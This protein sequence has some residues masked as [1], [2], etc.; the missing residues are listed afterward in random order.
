M[1]QRC[2][3]RLIAALGLMLV[4]Q[5]MAQTFTTLH[6]FTVS[7]G[8]NPVAALILSSNTL[9][10]TTSYGGDL[11]NGT[12]FTVNTDGSGFTNLYSFTGGSD[13]ANPTAGL[14]LLSNTLYGVA[15]SGGN[16]G[17]G[18]VFAI[19]TSGT[20]FTNLYSFTAT[21]FPS[22]TNGDGANP[23]GLILS[24]NTFYGTAN[25]GGSFGQGTIFKVNINGTGFT[26][27]HNFTRGSDGGSPNTGLILSSNILYGTTFSG[28][29]F[30]WGTVFAVGTDSTGFTNLHSFYGSSDGTD[31]AAGL[32]LSGN[33]LYGTAQTGGDSGNGTVFRI[34]TDGTGFTN[35]HVFIS[36]S[37]GANPQASFV[38][39]SNTLY[40]STGSGGNSGVGTLFSI[41]LNGT[42]FNN[43]YNFTATFPSYPY[44]NGDGAH[45]S[46][47]LILL[48]NILYGTAQYG[49][50]SGVGTVF[51]LDLR[52]RVFVAQIN[53][54]LILTWANT[55]FT[56]QSAPLVTG[57]YTNISGATSPYTNP[58][59]AS[60][61]F[62]RLIGN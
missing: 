8:A 26:N 43:L 30:G 28:G 48:D 39:S 54:Q 37:D 38:L 16:S 20:S 58:I 42:G 4:G 47:S 11:G 1:N 24:G 3:F 44:I 60:Q 15:S 61:Q 13:G 51:K 27:L 9:Y 62:F 7:D 34:Y 36:T 5:A 41:K 18:T 21:P 10:G 46:A 32:V 53:N 23:N 56:L 52:P 55:N 17:V 49:G 33:T 29:E 59:S 14:I 31:P 57:I 45:P 35:L 25:G 22:N 40:G 6:S 50:S 12:I 2:T 19:Y